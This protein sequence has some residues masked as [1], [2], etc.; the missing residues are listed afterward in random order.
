MLFMNNNL[1]YVSSN[2]FKLQ[3]T[4]KFFDKF[5]PE[6]NLIQATLDFIEPHIENQID[7]A[8]LKIIN[9]AFISIIY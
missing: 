6:I 3:M 8:I 7:I 9:N 4:Q 1:Y 5:A 2:K